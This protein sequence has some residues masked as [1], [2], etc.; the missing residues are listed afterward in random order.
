[1][2]ATVKRTLGKVWQT[3]KLNWVTALPFVLMDIRNSVTKTTSYSPH[4]LLTGK[5]M[6]KPVGSFTER[7][8]IHRLGQTA[9]LVCQTASRDCDAAAHKC[10]QRA[11]EQEDKDNS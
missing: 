5:E 4:L 3:A 11:H 1:M 6:Y 8:S 10:R 7:L 2:N 9:S